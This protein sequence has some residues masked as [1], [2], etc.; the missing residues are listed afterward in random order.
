MGSHLNNIDQRAEEE[1]QD[2][3]SSTNSVGGE[4]VKQGEN[5]SEDEEEE[6]KESKVKHYSDGNPL[7]KHKDDDEPDTSPG[8]VDPSIINLILNSGAASIN[9]GGNASQD[10]QK[11]KDEANDSLESFNE[12]FNSFLNH[13]APFAIFAFTSFL[14]YSYGS[15]FTINSYESPF[16]CSDS[17]LGSLLCGAVESIT[18]NNL[19]DYYKLSF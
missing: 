10:G 19:I 17:P 9:N 2:E 15:S 8:K 18:T 6:A 11:S 13:Q 14:I 1:T 5:D 4:E 16:S 12:M 3:N 7:K